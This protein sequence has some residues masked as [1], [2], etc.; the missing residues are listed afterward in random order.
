M[1]QKYLKCL[2]PKEWVCQICNKDIHASSNSNFENE[3]NDLNESPKFIITDVNL[4]KYDNILFNP[5]RFDYNSTI[6]W[7]N[8]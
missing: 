1:K 8:K 3:I 7:Y 2:N 5:L 4:T 6:K